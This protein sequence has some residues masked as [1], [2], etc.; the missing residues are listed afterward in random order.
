MPTVA[1]MLTG[2]AAQ[3]LAAEQVGTLATLRFC[4]T[5]E[6]L[7][8]LVGRGGVDAVVA[9]LHDA[10]GASILPAFGILHGHAPQL[11]LFLTVSLPPRRCVSCPSG[12]PVCGA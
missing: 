10:A 12:A 5:T 11:P 8:E 6:A 4:E 1:V 3:A 2:R 7:L 9:D